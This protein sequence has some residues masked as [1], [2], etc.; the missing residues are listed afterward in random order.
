MK[1]ID[2]NSILHIDAKIKHRSTGSPDEFARSLGISRSTLYEYL[3][4]IRQDFG[5]VILYDR[6]SHTYY[7]EGPDLVKAFYLQNI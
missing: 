3:A 6:Y 5:L 1:R 4:Y 2:L 7:Y